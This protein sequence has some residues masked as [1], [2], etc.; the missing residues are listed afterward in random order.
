LDCAYCDPR[1][2]E[3]VDGHEAVEKE[4]YQRLNDGQFWVKRLSLTLSGGAAPLGSGLIA[5]SFLESSYRLSSTLGLF[6]DSVFGF[7]CFFFDRSSWGF[8][9]LRTKRRAT[10]F[11][12]RVNVGDRVDYR[13]ACQLKNSVGYDE[14]VVLTRAESLDCSC[15]SS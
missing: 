5:V 3:L 1:A 7:D 11:P 14:R 10:V 4:I 2:Q 9:G 15:S 8:P 12:V 6:L 13:P